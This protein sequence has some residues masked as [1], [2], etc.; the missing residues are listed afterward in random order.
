[1]I[2]VFLLSAAAIVDDGTLVVSAEREPIAYGETGGALTVIDGATIEAV[3]LPQLVD[4][5]RLS[6][7]VSVARSGPTGAQ[8]QVRVRGWHRGYRVE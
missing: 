3:A 2:A 7:G 1:M 5:L 4:I 8:T 6:P